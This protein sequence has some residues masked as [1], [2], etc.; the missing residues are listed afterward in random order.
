MCCDRSQDSLT[1]RIFTLRAMSFGGS[2]SILL[3]VETVFHRF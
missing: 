3:L 1:D 2:L